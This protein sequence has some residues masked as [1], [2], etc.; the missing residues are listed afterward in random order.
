MGLRCGIGLAGFPFADAA[1]FWRWIELCER[2]DVDSFW[3]SDRLVSRDPQLES[4]TTMAALA[5]GTSRMKFGMNVTVVPF[6]DPLILAKQCATID[7][8]SNGRLLPAFGVGPAVAPE[9]KAMGLSK[10]GRG[11]RADEALRIMSRL[12][13]EESVS[14]EGDY[15]RYEDASISP[16]PVQNPLPLWIGGSSE[17]AIRRTAEIGTG[18]VAGIQTPEQVGPVV[19]RIQQLAREAG[20]PLDPEH[21]GAGVSYRFGSL[22]DPIVQKTMKGFQRFNPDLDPRRFFAAGGADAVLERIEDYRREGIFKFVLRP[23]ATGADDVM[24]QTTRLLEE[25]LPRVHGG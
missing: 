8:L 14:F 5:G 21:F 23:M 18:W 17:A 6:R 4:M 11:A 7:F 25:V 16:R 9:W 2:N 10:E 3:Q 20:R 13:S 12:W 1:G 22:D 15:Y 19:A 24:E